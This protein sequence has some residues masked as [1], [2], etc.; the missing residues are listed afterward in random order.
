[1]IAIVLAR[2]SLVENRPDG[3]FLPLS[4]IVRSRLVDPGLFS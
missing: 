1:M 3:R 2:N 4:T